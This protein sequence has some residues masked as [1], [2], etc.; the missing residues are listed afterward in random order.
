L[1][2]P[3]RALRGYAEITHNL[4]LRWLNDVSADLIAVQDPCP[5]FS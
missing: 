1:S 3:D 5:E 2:A 4:N